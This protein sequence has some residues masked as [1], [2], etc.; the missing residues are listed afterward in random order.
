MEWKS[1]SIQVALAPTIRQHSAEGAAFFKER[2]GRLWR[3]ANPARRA[4]VE[5]ASYF[6]PRIHPPTPQR[7]EHFR[8]KAGNFGL[9]PKLRAKRAGLRPAH[10]QPNRPNSEH[11]NREKTSK[12]GNK[13]GERT[14]TL[15]VALRSRQTFRR[16]RGLPRNTTPKARLNRRKIPA[17]ANS[18]SAMFPVGL[19]PTAPL[20]S[21]ELSRVR[22]AAGRPRPGSEKRTTGVRLTQPHRGGVF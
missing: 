21:S 10:G 3:P 14:L 17:P 4:F 22:F 11:S 12:Q 8:P 2:T 18:K 20:K 16:P 7:R 5:L 15:K 19:W 6:R 13:Y 9:C 1:K